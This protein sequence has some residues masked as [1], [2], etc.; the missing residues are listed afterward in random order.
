MTARERRRYPR[1]DSILPLSVTRGQERLATKTANVSCSGV[2]CH[3]PQPLSLMT[4]VAV[5]LALPRRT[6]QCVAVVVRCQRETRPTRRQGFQIALFFPD[7]SRA[8]H[9]AIAEYV[10]DSMMTHA[11]GRRRP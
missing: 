3:L 10:L 7:I 1:I 11:H 8:D 6:V 5:T 4:R 2:M 9:R